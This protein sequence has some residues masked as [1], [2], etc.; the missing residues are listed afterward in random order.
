[1]SF[2][3]R[4]GELTRMIRKQ[5]CSRKVGGKKVITRTAERRKRAKVDFYQKNANEKKTF[6]SRR[7]TNWEEKK[8]GV[9]ARAEIVGVIELKREKKTKDLLQAP[10]KRKTN[11]QSHVLHNGAKKKSTRITGKSSA[12]REGKKKKLCLLERGKLVQCRK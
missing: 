5:H 11:K 3:A 6:L 1:M 9:R 7:A 4:E 12:I 10:K 2:R 8:R